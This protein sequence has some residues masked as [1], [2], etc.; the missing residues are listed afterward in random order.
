[1]PDIK[2]VVYTR[3]QGNCYPKGLILADFV[4]MWAKIEFKFSIAE[5]Q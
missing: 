5:N 2:A 3:V 4:K 1:L